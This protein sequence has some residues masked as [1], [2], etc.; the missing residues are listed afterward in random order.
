MTLLNSGVDLA[1]GMA[2]LQIGWAA[3]P[4]ASAAESTVNS[5][6]ERR[7]LPVQRYRITWH[8]RPSHSSALNVDEL[9]KTTIANEEDEAAAGGEKEFRQEFRKMVHKVSMQS[10]IL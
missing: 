2:W 5:T 8:H 7:R 6:A 9:T 1:N 4:F 3:P 10:R